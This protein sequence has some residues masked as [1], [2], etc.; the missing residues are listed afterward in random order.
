MMANW[1]LSPTKRFPDP[2]IYLLTVGMNDEVIMNALVAFYKVL[3]WT[4]LANTYKDKV[5]SYYPGLDLTK[6]NYIHSGVS[7]SYRHS[8]P[9][10][11]LYY[12]PF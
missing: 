11:S 9:Y 3:G 7:F 6:T 2:Q 5:A 10:L 12:S 8:K 4:D 1:T